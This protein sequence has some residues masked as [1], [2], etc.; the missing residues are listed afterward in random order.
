MTSARTSLAWLVLASCAWLGCAAPSRP[1]PGGPSAATSASVARDGRDGRDLPA[2]AASSS[3]AGASG[4][5][6]CPVGTRA[7]GGG[8]LASAETT[9]PASMKF[10][11]G[12]GCIADG[13]APRAEEGYLRAMAAY[14]AWY[15]SGPKVGTGPEARA[16]A[17]GALS[18]FFNGTLGD[19]GAV[20]Y[21]VEAAYHVAEILRV[22]DEKDAGIWLRRTL[23]AYDRARAA[24]LAAP[25]T[26]PATLAAG[27]ELAGVEAELWSSFDYETGH[28]RFGGTPADVL[29]KHD[30]AAVRG[31]ELVLRLVKLA[32]PSTYGSFRH[33]VE[34]R[35]RQASVYESLRASLLRAEVAVWTAPHA[36]EKDARV[37]RWEARLTAHTISAIE[38]A[39]RHGVVL[40]SVKR[41]WERLGQ[42]EK[43]IGA[44]KMRTYAEKVPGFVYRDEMFAGPAPE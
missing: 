20:V 30:E 23:E 22:G 40:G 18:G 4:G 28:L 42:L 12:H 9:C 10:E 36:G 16:K 1:E 24:G 14:L 41:A 34:A 37:E 26:R 17:F 21:A 39:R 8:C 7:Q 33:A 13:P 29:K 2:S 5:G 32:E 3:S 25:G 15:G 19:P 6:P 43:A 35:L 44:A 11:L 31:E 27:A 38:L